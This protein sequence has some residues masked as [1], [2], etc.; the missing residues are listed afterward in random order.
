MGKNDFARDPL[1]YIHQPSISTPE[2][3]M[4]S[5]YQTPQSNTTTTNTIT[6]IT[7]PKVDR[8]IDEEQMAT[9][10]IQ[11][12]PIR[13]T[14]FEKQFNKTKQ[15]DMDAA[16]NEEDEDIADNQP[17]TTSPEDT[18]EGN[19]PIKFKDRSIEEKIAYFADAPEFAPK[20]RCEVKTE[21]RTYRGYIV[22]RQED[23]VSMRTGKRTTNISAT[24]II[25]IRMLG[26]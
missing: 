9:K 8:N 10:K 16:K 20:M 26:F 25:D 22:D 12:Q 1:L 21:E 13:K 24:K 23:T 5:D 15:E 19:E 18:S 17:K 2:A 6:S 14:A 11:K 3:P 7:A 4:Q